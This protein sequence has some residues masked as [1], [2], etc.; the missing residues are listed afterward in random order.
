VTAETLTRSKDFSSR[1][2]EKAARY[3]S[4]LWFPASPELLEKIRRGLEKREYQSPDALFDDVKGDLSLFLFSWKELAARFRNEDRDVP[5]SPLDLYRQAGEQMLRDVFQT[6]I[7]NISEHSLRAINGAQSQRFRETL[8]SASTAEVLSQESGIGSDEA[9]GAGVLRQLGLVLISFNYPTVY[10]SAIA[11]LQ[12]GHS[13]DESLAKEL[14]F[15][16][17]LLAFHLMRKWGLGENYEEVVRAFGAKPGSEKVGAAAL[18]VSKLCEVGEALA[19]ANHPEVYPSAAH[20]WSYAKEHIE[21]SLGKRGLATVRKQLKENTKAYVKEAP[22]IFRGAAL[23]DPEMAIAR[24]W[25]EDH[26]RKNPF[27]AHCRD[28]FRRTMCDVYAR[29]RGVSTPREC[30]GSLVK[31]ALPQAGFTGLCIYTIDPTTKLF[32]PQLKVGALRLRDPHPVSFQ[33]KSDPIT[34]AFGT[35]VPLIEHVRK[36]DD[37]HIT[38]LTWLLGVSNRAGVLYAEIDYSQFSEPEIDYL[39][40]FKSLSKAFSDCLSLG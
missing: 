21:K 26:Y 14:G 39:A 24:R 7:R 18:T 6:P 4:D 8:V 5:E 20:D 10:E 30:L 9:Y 1:R 16:P 19:R 11:G 34:I 31:D 25:D 35:S 15:T 17:S 33:E 27:L 38:Y 32:L 3:V 37:E 23:L 36:S 13:L 22:A 29:L 40:H 12:S 2:L 28:P